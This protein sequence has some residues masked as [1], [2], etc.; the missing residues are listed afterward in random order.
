MTAVQDAAHD[1]PPRI[2]V[3]GSIN[4]DLVMRVP[5]APAAGETLLGHSIGTIAGGK[6]ANQ[7][8]S[9]ARQGARVQM[10]GCVGED[11]NGAALREALAR[12]GVDTAQV[13]TVAD[14]STGVALILVEDSGQNRIVMVPGANARLEVDPG[15]LGAQLRDAAFL[16]LQFETPLEQIG[17]AIAAAREAGCKVMLNPSP[18]QDFAQSWWP[19]IDTLVVNELEAQALS[20]LRA[21]APQEAAQAGRA[22]RA[23]GA[24]RVVVTMGALGAVAVDEAGA[25]HHP[26]PA[27]QP[28][29]STAAGDTLLGALA[30]ALAEGA[31]LDA[32][33]STGIR[34]AA[35]CVQRA[36][37]QPSIPHRDEVLRGPRPPDWRPL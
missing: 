18:V 17:H 3:L 31:D 25:R 32:A 6:G 35:L 1:A 12:E 11:A 13:R 29:D 23:R 20:G 37:A 36:G 30:A 14:A 4:M 16:V 9:C 7:A 19:C 28:V 33:L 34:A 10:I 22:L 15:A 21:D 26:A 2:V 24:R 5:H 8:V 27:V